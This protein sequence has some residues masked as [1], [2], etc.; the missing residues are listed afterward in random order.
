MKKILRLI[1]PIVLASASL[2]GCKG[3]P[4]SKEQ[5][6]YIKASRDVYLLDDEANKPTFSVDSEQSN[7]PSTLKE[8]D[9]KLNFVDVGSTGAQFET[10]KQKG[11]IAKTPG[12]FVVSGTLG[13]FT[14]KN[15]ISIDVMYSSEY[16][17]TKIQQVI[18][19]QP[20]FGEA[21]DIGISASAL[22]KYTLEG[23]DGIMQFASDGRLEVCGI[24]GG[25]IVLKENGNVVYS[26][27]YRVYQSI[28]CTK[29]QDILMGKGLIT[30]RTDNVSKDMLLNVTAIDLAE[31]IKNDPGAGMGVRFLANL[32]EINLSNN[33]LETVE[34][35]E[36]LTKLKK[37]NFSHNQ[38]TD[39]ESCFNS[40]ETLEYIDFND[41]LATSLSALQTFTSL[42]YLDI[43]NNEIKNI[44]FIS[45][46]FTL[47]TLKLNNNKLEVFR[48]G[49]SGLNNLT[50]LALG[51]TGLSFTDIR[52]LSYINQLVSLD[53]SDS[54]P[55]IDLLKNYTNLETLIM[56]DCKL[57]N[58]D[59]SKL[60]SLVN[61]K[62][63]DLS[64]NKLEELQLTNKINPEAL[65]KIEYFGIGGNEINAIPAFVADFP[66]LK[67]LDLTD[68]YNL[69][70]ITSIN[71]LN[72]EELI[73]DDCNSI[74]DHLDNP[75][76]YATQ[77]EAT[78][79]SLTHLVRL[80]LVGGLNYVSQ[81]LYDYLVDRVNNNGLHL[82]LLEDIYM[83]ADNIYNYPYAISFSMNDFI[84]GCTLK[85]GDKYLST[86]Y[87][88]FILVLAN[89]N[90]A[91]AIA[92]QRFIVPKFARRIDIYGNPSK[93]YNLAFALEAR[94]Q[95]SLQFNLFNFEDRNDGSYAFY[96]S[97]ARG[98][99][100]RV[101][102]NRSVNSCT[103]INRY[104]EVPDNCHVDNG[105]NTS[106]QDNDNWT[107]ELEM[108]I[109][110]FWL[111]GTTVMSGKHYVTKLDALSM[112]ARMR[113]PYNQIPF[114]DGRNDSRSIS[115]DGNAEGVNLA[116]SGLKAKNG[117]GTLG[118]VTKY[119]DGTESS[120][121][122]A[123]FFQNKAKD[124][125]INVFAPANVKTDGKDIQS[126][127]VYIGFE[128]EHARGA[129][130]IGQKYSNWLYK[131][132]FT[133]SQLQ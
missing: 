128:I 28:L 120:F 52:S 49:L 84:T 91:E 8:E 71:D 74:G 40:R 41:N 75:Y 81:D 69:N 9:L 31:D 90:S 3:T 88:H 111:D 101:V 72:I 108:D 117:Y 80:S 23:V 51:Y 105:W 87:R 93:A 124:A 125:V 104:A 77:I 54:T 55:T 63:L 116:D 99:N 36:P 119:T 96:R 126:I 129:L 5:A 22:A 47:E 78:I 17:K 16:V 68:S 44:D 45:G 37:I 39:I 73:L 27:P 64:N 43:S 83:D 59:L 34:F 56:K 62:K 107:Y 122:R 79:E 82:R 7:L 109:C 110:D 25:T 33:N 115:N 6:L 29:I 94:K 102:I 92:E 103:R 132:S 127:S 18:T 14:S 118:V 76:A 85:D 50:E 61:L 60:N 130:G 97:L 21:Y 13:E 89:D 95:A 131:F 24:G 123:N 1:F 42:K 106:V 11:I 70:E 38:I 100:P 35:L 15:N 121:V 48:D 20:V 57:Y 86:R 46:V 133:F 113:Y 67:T 66:Q 65:N 112:Y 26:Y 98:E 4:Q 53:I 32:E 2:F 12:T 10:N 19:G 30:R 58:Q 114:K